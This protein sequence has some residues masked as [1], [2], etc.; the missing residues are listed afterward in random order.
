MTSVQAVLLIIAA[1]VA[2]AA[3]LLAPR[4]LRGMTAS[5]PVDEIER[6]LRR[7]GPGMAAVV[8]VLVVWYTWGDL[9]PIAKVHDEV[10]YVLQ[11]QIFARGRWTAPSPPIPEFFEQPHVMVV[12]A[13]ASKYPPGHALML[14]PGA[15]VG[16]PA[17]MPL[18]L[19]GLTAALLFVLATRVYN[20]WV[21]VL[22]WMLWLTAPLVLRFQASFFSEL[23]TTATILSSWWALLNWRDTRRRHWLLLVAL[24]MGW[25]AITRPLTALAFAI[26]IAVVVLRDV[27]RLNRWMD[28]ALAML[29][30]TAVVAILPLWSAKT[31]GSWRV[32]PIELYRR[33]Y[34]AYD[35]VGFTV[36]TAAP[37]RGE[38]P[39]LKAL[40]EYFLA[41]HMQQTVARLP[42]TAYERF[43]SVTAAF[44]QNWRLPLLVFALAGFLAMNAALR[45]AMF[46]ALST[47]LAHL[48]YAHYPG[49][50]IYYFETAAAISTLTAVGLWHMARV[51]L[52]EDREMKVAAGL[53]TILLVAFG[54]VNWV[55]W[56]AEHYARA[57]F[58]RLFAR[59]I[60]KL[61]A[62][63]AIVFIHYT[64]RSDQHISVVFN[65]PDLNAAPV[66]VVHDL[67]PRNAE[68][69]R[70]APNRASFDFDEDQLMDVPLLR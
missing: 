27:G 36:D 46:S 26:P 11:A 39:V 41:P 19:T 59:E 32:T 24:F 44:F 9:V 67:G 1:V 60:Q 12:P 61:P 37:R 4:Y 6:G 38:T 23:T 28:L 48:S 5:I 33:D 64:P 62:R 25:C 42:L 49:W 55:H 22:S 50:T 16:F 7:F 66:W 54:A 14:T 30:G 43:V 35:K 3:A 21:G 17:L 69:R 57:G 70:L 15:L 56:R 18:V 31:T 29:V 45:F 13:V 34:M 2:F 20:P 10:S 53:A 52:A 47:F 65:Y 8:S 63:P 68:L 58:D 51:I 40:N